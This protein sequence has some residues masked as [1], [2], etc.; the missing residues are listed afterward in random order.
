MAPVGM[1]VATSDTN[2]SAAIIPRPRNLPPVPK[3]KVAASKYSTQIVPLGGLTDKRGLK[4]GLG[5]PDD[6]TGKLLKGI[7]G[8]AAVLT[9]LWAMTGTMVL[10]YSS[11]IDELR[12]ELSL[13]HGDVVTFSAAL[14]ASR[15]EAASLRA[16]LAASRGV[17]AQ[18]G[19]VS[20]SRNE[21]RL[22]EEYMTEVAALREEVLVLIDQRRRAQIHCGVGEYP[23]GV[24]EA[25][26][27]SCPANTYSASG[28]S[29]LDCPP[30][31]HPDSLASHC[32]EDAD[33]VYTPPILDYWL[34]VTYLVEDLA[35]FANA[36]A[37]EYTPHPPY[38]AIY[39]AYLTDWFAIT[40]DGMLMA[41][42]SSHAIPTTT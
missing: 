24:S 7:A 14:N 11:D 3:K 35:W 41:V 28:V 19:T 1:K 22:R 12:G 33:D 9:V 5:E 31:M 20:A 15:T 16:E 13:L 2:G 26:C 40:E 38:N 32:T 42:V 6:K 30:G 18:L 39:R 10:G 8:W 25:P 23:T 36:D 21:T 29:C 17:V 37:R 34:A 27:A 4:L